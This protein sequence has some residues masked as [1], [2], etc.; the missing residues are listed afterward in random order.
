MLF[1]LTKHSMPFWG[2]IPFFMLKKQQLSG[3]K[4]DENL[5]VMTVIWKKFGTTVDCHVS[6]NVGMTIDCHGNILPDT[7]EHNE[8]G[9]PKASYFSPFNC[10]FVA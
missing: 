1:I 8:A 3:D 10:C 6:M 4:L 5:I 2:L 7:N 9:Q